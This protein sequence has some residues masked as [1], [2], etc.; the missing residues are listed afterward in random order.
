[1]LR[2]CVIFFSMEKKITYVLGGLFI[3][4]AIF[5]AQYEFSRY[6]KIKHDVN[7]IAPCVQEIIPP[8]SWSVITGKYRGGIFG[9]EVRLPNFRKECDQSAT[10]T[11]CSKISSIETPIIHENNPIIPDTSPSGKIDE[12][13]TINN[14]LRDVN[15]CGKTYKV[16]QVM[17]DGV[18]VVQRVAEIVTKSQLDYGKEVCNTA[19]ALRTSGWLKLDENEIGVSEVVIADLENKP[20]QVSLVSP[21]GNFQHIGDFQIDAT[22]GDIFI[23]LQGIDGTS[24]KLIGKLK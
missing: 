15:F 4:L 11:D 12:H 9:S 22:T 17:I 14:E 18:D 20:Y 16:K 8:S 2:F 24:S 19:N 10:T 7:C 5:C 13:L 6:Q 3:L 23:I 1:M 21:T